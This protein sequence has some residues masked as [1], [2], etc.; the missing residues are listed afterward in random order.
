MLQSSGALQSWQPHPQLAETQPLS[1]PGIMNLAFNVSRNW[2]G[3]KE[4]GAA[5]LTSDPELRP[6]T[7]HG[8]WEDQFITECGDRPGK[9]EL[10]YSAA[11][12]LAL[13]EGCSLP[14]STE[15]AFSQGLITGEEQYPGAP[16]AVSCSLLQGLLM[17]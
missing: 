8:R 15:E 16:G 7:L 5:Q 11:R 14:E 1:P 10:P 4:T 9:P 12:A 6:A 17:R 13:R 3:E 2:A